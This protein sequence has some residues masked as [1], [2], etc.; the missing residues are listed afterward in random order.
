MNKDISLR[1]FWKQFRTAEEVSR[2]EENDKHQ[3]GE[4]DWATC[5]LCIEE[6]GG[7]DGSS[8]RGR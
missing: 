8:G 1:D 4:C 3:A 5:R 7:A 2:D 6:E